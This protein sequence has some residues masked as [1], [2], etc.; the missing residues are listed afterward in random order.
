MLMTTRERL[1]WRNYL[2][3]GC[4][5][6]GVIL[7]Y[8][9]STRVS[10]RTTHAF[11]GLIFALLFCALGIIYRT[12]CT[13]CGKELGIV[14]IACYPWSSAPRHCPHCRASFDAD[15]HKAT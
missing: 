3:A 7:L 11:K 6:L 13:H 5:V 9:A 2:A 14:A 15:R 8:V 10:E 1:I 12:R 4:V